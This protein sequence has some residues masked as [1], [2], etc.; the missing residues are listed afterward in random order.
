M[1]KFQKTFNN[2]IKEK[3]YAG[4]IKSIALTGATKERFIV[5]GVM[6]TY[7]K[8]PLSMTGYYI[9]PTEIGNLYSISDYHVYCEDQ[10]YNM[11]ISGFEPNGELSFTTLN[12]DYV[13]DHEEPNDRAQ[14]F[15]KILKNACKKLH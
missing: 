14:Q 8:E 12:T 15:S 2:L 10:V 1:H 13:F 5:T 9:N 11:V 3:S 6:S 4:E 7:K